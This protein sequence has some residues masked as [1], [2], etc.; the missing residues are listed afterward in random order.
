[1]HSPGGLEQPAAHHRAGGEHP[2]RH[3]AGYRGILQADAYAGFNDLYSEARKPDPVT[4][5]LCWA[6]GRR[7]FFKLA[8]LAKAPLAIEAVQRIDA[9]FDIE[10][11]INSLLY[12]EA[13]ACLPP[14]H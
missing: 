12:A 9:I 2:Q 14:V 1:M 4:Q 7:Y 3:L 13:L 5:A 6:H 8:E 10:R 11:T